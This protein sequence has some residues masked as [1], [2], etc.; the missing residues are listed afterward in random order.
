LSIETGLQFVGFAPA[1]PA[2]TGRWISSLR[3]INNV[4]Q[5]FE[6]IAS[7]MFLNYASGINSNG[8]IRVGGG[9]FN[10]TIFKEIN[11]L[12]GISTAVIT[13]VSSIALELT[14]ST[15][16]APGGLPIKVN[17]PLEFVSLN[18]ITNV[19]VINTNGPA[20]P[21]LAIA[22]S[23]IQLNAANVRTE[24]LSTIQHQ[25]STLSASTI[26]TGLYQG[27]AIGVSSM[28]TVQ[29]ALSTIQMY[30]QSGITPPG[31]S[32]LMNIGYGYDIS[33]GAN[34]FWIEN[35]INSV[36][37]L[38]FGLVG[39]ADGAYI[40][41]WTNGRSSYSELFL[42]ANT[43]TLNIDD[44]VLVSDNNSGSFTQIGPTYLTTVDLNVSTINGNDARPA[45]T[46]NL[47]LSSMTLI[48][49]STTLMYWDTVTTSSNINT[50]TYDAQV[51]VT[52]AYKIG[53][54]FQFISAGSSDEVEF[55]LLKNN[56][57]I[58]QSGGIV[59]VQ[60]NA[61]EISYAES[62]EQLIEGDTIQIG[63]FTNGSGV[64]VSTINGNVIQSPACILT[65]YKV[66]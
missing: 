14:V 6:A 38:D 37:N 54:S 41:S 60:N 51:R 26:T 43:M 2:T 9:A 44:S 13:A 19:D 66:D 10:D 63:C 15:I 40:T 59:E 31:L 29:L 62:V 21:V 16:K 36:D 1:N 11:G 4:G 56:S 8:F 32:S 17:N 7:T 35:Y 47:T 22:A 39:N 42:K 64:F 5:D 34:G 45:Y 53:A 18:G 65:M 49:A 27:Q 57:V 58:S 61:E 25:T 50:S 12:P 24:S 33:G 3:T 28:S 23:T 48:P 46:N 52:G 55:F 30:E 20:V